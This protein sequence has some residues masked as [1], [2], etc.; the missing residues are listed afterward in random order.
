MLRELPQPAHHR[1]YKPTN[2]TTMMRSLRLAQLPTVVGDGII[3]DPEDNPRISPVWR[4]AAARV[5]YTIIDCQ[6][7]ITVFG[8]TSFDCQDYLR[9]AHGSHLVIAIDPWVTVSL[10]AIVS[11]IAAGSGYRP[12]ARRRG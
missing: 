10:N 5:S 3:R 2:I 1:Q 6:K 8:V 7:V 9:N 4:S 12:K 11:Q